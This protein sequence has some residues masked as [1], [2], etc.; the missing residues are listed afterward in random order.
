M[1]NGILFGLVTTFGGGEVRQKEGVTSLSQSISNLVKDKYKNSI[2]FIKTLPTS[3]IE[4]DR[5]FNTMNPSA[6]RAAHKRLK[7]LEPLSQKDMDLVYKSLN[8][9]L[10]DN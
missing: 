10:E 8:T 1:R 4:Y 2:L 9:L 5:P 7:V 6:F 3:V